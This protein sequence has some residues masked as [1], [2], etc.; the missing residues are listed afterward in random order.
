MNVTIGISDMAISRS[1]DDELITYSLGS[2]LGLLLHDPVT[3]IAGMV[4]CLLPLS[5]MDAARAASK[6]ATFVD[7]GVVALL[8]AVLDSGADKRRLVAKAVGCAN[9]IVDQ[10]L[11]RIGERNYTV[12]R[13]VLWKNGIM[14]AA[15][16][17]GGT[18]ARTVRLHVGTGRAVVRANGQERE[19]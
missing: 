6:P 11:F 1:P 12:L 3:K 8:Q 17:V 2:C 10:G 5:S 19:I 16:D 15:E 9:M 14:I 18:I 13:K 7:T 4:H